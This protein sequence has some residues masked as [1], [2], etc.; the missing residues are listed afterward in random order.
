MDGVPAV[1]ANQLQNL[2]DRAEITDL[3]SVLGRS[4][5]EHRFDDL[6]DVFT[7]DA[8]AVTPGGTQNGRAGLIAQARANHEAYDR[9]QHQISSILIDVDGDRATVRANLMGTFAHSADPK[10]VRQLGGLYRCSAVRT[11]KGWRFDDLQVTPIWR[12]Q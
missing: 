4:L 3:L 2:I 10:P 9:L 5:D 6:E 8:T 11:E 7:E 1:S 12:V